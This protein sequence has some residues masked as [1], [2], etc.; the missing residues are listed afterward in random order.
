[1]VILSA[2]KWRHALLS[3]R[4]PSFGK[5]ISECRKACKWSLRELASKV[6]K[7]DGGNITPQYLNDIEHGRRTPSRFVI[8]EFARVLNLDEDY[9][10]S[11]AGGQPKDVRAYLEKSPD[12]GPE[13]AK[14]FRR[15]KQLRFNVD[16]WGHVLRTMEDRRKGKKPS[17]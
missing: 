10:L 14:V 12:M 13:V 5:E 4:K 16:D 7:E 17:R 15:A 2:D 8:G 6:K 3:T 11:L 1:M 9:L